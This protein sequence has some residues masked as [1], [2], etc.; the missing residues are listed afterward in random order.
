MAST[1]GWNTSTGTG[2]IGNDQS[3]NNSSGFN[4]F[5]EGFRDS[6]ASFSGEGK[7]SIFWNSTMYDSDDE[8]LR[9]LNWSLSYLLRLEGNT[10]QDGLSVRF[11]R[12]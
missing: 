6:D 1:T 7:A 4:T 12:D 3:T 2:A 10:K 9:F 8:S 11:V 5:P